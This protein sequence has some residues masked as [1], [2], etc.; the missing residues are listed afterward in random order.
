MFPQ[1]P[2]WEFPD[3]RQPSHDPSWPFPS[4]D[5]CHNVSACYW[6]PGRFSAGP[7][8]WNVRIFLQQHQ[9]CERKL[10]NDSSILFILFRKSLRK[11]CWK[12]FLILY[13]FGERWECSPHFPRAHSEQ[14]DYNTETSCLL[15]LKQ[16]SDTDIY[17]LFWAKIPSKTINRH[18]QMCFLN[19]FQYE[20]G[21]LEH[22]VGT[23]FPDLG[24]LKPRA[25]HPLPPKLVEVT[26][27]E[28]YFTKSHT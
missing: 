12:L 2:L 21:T 9:I 5:P 6:I 19:T 24:C 22:A 3:A 15:L 25:F 10:G 13:F 23:I 16:P 17:R 14:Q 4:C 7:H 27:H 1:Q 18:S 26:N 8:H 11:P 20:Y 28:S